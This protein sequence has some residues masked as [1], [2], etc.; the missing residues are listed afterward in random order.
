MLLTTDYDI[1]STE[2]YK[3][4]SWVAFANYWF[5]FQIL[6]YLELPLYALQSK[7]KAWFVLPFSLLEAPS[8]G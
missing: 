2:S 8:S 7:R 4:D 3:Q 5:R 1:S 6:A